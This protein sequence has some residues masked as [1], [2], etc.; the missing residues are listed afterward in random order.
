M[1]LAERIAD[2]QHR[3]AGLVEELRGREV[4]GGQHRDARAV[5]V[6]LGDVDDG[7]AAGGLGGG[8][9]AGS[10]CGLG[11]RASLRGGVALVQRGGDPVEEPLGDLAL[12]QQRQ[13]VARP[14][15]G[16]DR[17]PVRVGPEAG[18][19]L[20]DVV[21]DEQVD[22]L[23]AELLGGALERAGLGREADEDGTRPDGSRVGAPSLSRPRAIRATSASRSGVGFELEGQAV[24]RARA[25]GRRRSPAGSRRRRRP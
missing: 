23:A 20:G 9:H 18:A 5:G 13:V 24:G 19:R 6:Q 3:D 2:E 12:G 1:H 11:R 17:D 21:G 7:Q 15:G 25:C 4:V 16:Q 10:R 8:A 14:V 22:A